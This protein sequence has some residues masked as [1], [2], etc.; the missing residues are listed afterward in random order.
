VYASLHV[1]QCVVT[2][3]AVLAA[4]EAFLGRS[5]SDRI[6][7]CTRPACIQM[8]TK[9]STAGVEAASSCH[10]VLLYAITRLPLA[11]TTLKHC[12]ECACTNVLWPLRLKGVTWTHIPQDHTAAMPLR[13]PTSHFS[14]PSPKHT[15]TPVLLIPS[16]FLIRLTSE[17]GRNST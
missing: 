4:R 13:P 17:M 9:A 2:C 6:F 16:L 10:Q 15:V 12:L 8:Y 3:V 11:P 1:I 14:R 7:V 5:N